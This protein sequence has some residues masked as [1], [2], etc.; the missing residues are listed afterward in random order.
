[1]NTNTVFIARVQRGATSRNVQNGAGHQWAALPGT[2]F[3]SEWN[4]S[5]Q[6][7]YTLTL[8]MVGTEDSKSTVSRATLGILCHAGMCFNGAITKAN[9][10]LL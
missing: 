3:G 7:S 2:F 1:M 6:A 10:V 8:R 9:E 4:N 5:E